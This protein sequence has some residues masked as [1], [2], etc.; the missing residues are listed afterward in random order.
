LLA[1]DV[2]LSSCRSFTERSKDLFFEFERKDSS[3]AI[4]GIRITETSFWDN[5]KKA[6]SFSRS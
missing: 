1:V 4:V 6:F 2:R 5:L 3:P